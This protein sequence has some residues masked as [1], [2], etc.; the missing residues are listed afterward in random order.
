MCLTVGFFYDEKHWAFF[1]FSQWSPPS[2]ER[3]SFSFSSWRVFL[4]VLVFFSPGRGQSTPSDCRRSRCSGAGGF[5]AVEKTPGPD[6]RRR[7]PRPHSFRKKFASL[8]T[9][10]ARG[11]R[12]SPASP[13]PRRSGRVFLPLQRSRAI[14][15]GSP[16]SETGMLGTSPEEKRKN[17]KLTRRRKACRDGSA[18]RG[19]ALVM[20]KRRRGS[21]ECSE[22]AEKKKKKTR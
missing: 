1:F 5:S 11:R 13:R 20:W 14:R 4:F 15:Q 19:V 9:A 22:R 7:E 3:W 21:P 10:V 16:S 6:G 2:L 12:Q 18:G 8:E 17:A